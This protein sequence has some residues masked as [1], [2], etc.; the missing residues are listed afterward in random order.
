MIYYKSVVNLT[1]LQRIAL[2]IYSYLI[3]Q[4]YNIKGGCG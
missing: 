3:Q 1:L 4:K 2:P